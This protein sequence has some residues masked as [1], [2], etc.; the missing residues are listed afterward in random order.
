VRRDAQGALYIAGLRLVATPG[1]RGFSDW[2][3][4][5]RELDVRA[6]QIEW[7]DEQRGAPPLLLSGLNLR[8]VNRGTH[9][10]A[11]LTARL[12]EAVGST[13]ELRAQLD[14][15]DVDDRR[16]W[17]GRIYAEIGTTDLAAGRAWLDYPVDLERGQGALRAWATLSDGQVREATADLA[18]SDVRA[19]LAPDLPAFA[20]ARLTGRLQGRRNGDTYQLSATALKLVPPDG[21]ALPAVEFELAGSAAGGVVSANTLELVPLA[22]L[23]EALPLPAELRRVARELEPRGQLAELRYEWQ[24][25]LAAPK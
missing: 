4:D 18:L 23:G 20:L 1:E 13:L 25:P 16:A 11:S 24:G 15:G 10:A 14:S 2:L 9:H 22:H 5:Q 19:K 17:S 21:P 8:I 6:A 12:P 3:F 7:R